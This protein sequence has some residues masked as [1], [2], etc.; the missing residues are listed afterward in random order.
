MGQ[1]KP[2]R[3]PK[4]TRKPRFQNQWAAKP[5]ENTKEHKNISEP[6]GNENHREYKNNKTQDFRTNRREPESLILK[7]FFY[8]L[9]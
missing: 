5:I 6:M 8:F 2:S 4:Q 1:Q 7:L 9:F 3:I